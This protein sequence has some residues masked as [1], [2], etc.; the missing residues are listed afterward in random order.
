MNPEHPPQ[1]KA[2]HECQKAHLK[3]LLAEDNLVNQKITVLMLQKIACHVDIANNGLEV[4]EL[5]EKTAYDIILMDIQMPSMDGISATKIIRQSSPYQPYIIALTANA[6][7]D[8]QTKCLEAG[9]N[10]F[11]RKPVSAAKLIETIKKFVPVEE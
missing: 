1:V 9:M 8:N 7:D 11:L 2:V 4:L 3:I 5:L 10:D 6:L